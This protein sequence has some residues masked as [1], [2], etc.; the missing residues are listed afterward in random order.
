MMVFA[1]GELRAS[2]FGLKHVI[3]AR[4]GGVAEQMNCRKSRTINFAR[5]SKPGGISNQTGSRAAWAL[6]ELPIQ[7]SRWLRRG[8]LMTHRRQGPRTPQ[9]IDDAKGGTII[10]Q[11]CSSQAQGSIFPTAW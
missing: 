11:A 5:Y 9:A 8:L 4:S 2:Y 1:C 7:K 3:P 10:E 6:P